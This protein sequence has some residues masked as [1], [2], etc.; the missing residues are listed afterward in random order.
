MKKKDLC[1]LAPSF[2]ITAIVALSAGLDKIATAFPAI[3][4][5]NIQILT[6]LPSLI[7]V[8]VVLLSGY[9]T[10]KFTKKQIVSVAVLLMFLGGTFPLLCHSSFA[11]L[12]VASCVFGLGYGAIS[13][14]SSA[15]I[16][17]HYDRNEQA[18]MLGYQ[19]AVIGVGGMLFSYLGAQLSEK[20]WWYVYFSYLLILPVFYLTVKMPQGKRSERTEHSFSFVFSV[21]PFFYLCQCLLFHLFFYTFQNNLALY[22]ARA[23][24][25]RPGFAGVT[26]SAHSAI[27]IV[28]GLL[29]GAILR[30]LDFR[31][32][33]F[34]SLVSGIGLLLVFAFPSAFSAM[35][36][37]LLLGAV[38]SLRMP[39]GYMKITS[40]VPPSLSTFAIAVYCS[41]SQIGHFLSPIVTNSLCD[42]LGL[43][44]H[45][46]FLFSGCI[47][48]ALAIVTFFWSK[49]RIL[50]N[51]NG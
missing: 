44:L 3:S 8:A 29:C 45:G 19:S 6:S 1:L 31:S 9:L 33:S 24:I 15:L 32:I 27:G 22:L 35:S 34:V 39:A 7:A 36:C 4:T 48:V 12:L 43:D 42:V 25:G 13:S 16:A 20:C 26:F 23:Q 37:G 10:T 40:C 18:K 46:Q 41:M 21:E 17:E 14:L 11:L 5:S 30:K 49:E 47:L 28:T 50:K 38:F 2:L 51:K